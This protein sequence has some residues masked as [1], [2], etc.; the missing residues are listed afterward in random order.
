MG[1]EIKLDLNALTSM[2][3]RA[4]KNIVIFEEAAEKERQNIKQWRKMVEVLEEK[5]E[6]ESNM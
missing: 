4:K 6:R 2:I 3:E 5:H 1:K